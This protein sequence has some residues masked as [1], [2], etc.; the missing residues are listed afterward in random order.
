MKQPSQA[1]ESASWA[2][3]PLYYRGRDSGLRFWQVWAEGQELSTAYGLVGGQVQF[4][5]RVC[6]SKGKGKARTTPEQQAIKE[7]RAKHQNKLDRK[8]STTSE[9][10]TLPLELP[11]LAKS[12]YNKDMSVTNVGQQLL[13]SQ[14]DV[15]PKLDGVRALARW[16]HGRI[17]LVSRSGF[18][19]QGLEHLTEPMEKFVP[20]GWEIDGELYVHGINLQTI[21]SWVPKKNAKNMKPERTRLQYWM[22]DVPV[23]DGDESL[24]WFNRRWY[25][26]NTKN[27]PGPLQDLESSGHHR[28]VPYAECPDLEAFRVMEEKMIQRGFE[29]AMLRSHEG[30]YEYG[31]RSPHLLKAKRFIDEEFEITDFTDGEG[32]FRGCVVFKCLLHGHEGESPTPKNSFEVVP[33]GSTELRKAMFDCGSQLIGSKLTVRYQ[34]ETEDGKPFI[35]VGIP[36]GAIIRHAMDDPE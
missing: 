17:I 25:L 9:E 22:F 23:V 19:F 14:F 36:D 7:A 11:M 30:L 18:E 34:K 6:A 1:P 13:E 33:R 26:R 5:H 8:Y 12:F 2:G 32:K 27:H 16:H 28:V 29:G 20:K 4:S 3:Q 10:A 15:Q 31:H 24:T 21:N 35:P